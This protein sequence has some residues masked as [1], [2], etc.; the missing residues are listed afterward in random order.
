MRG[1]TLVVR[2]NTGIVDTSRAVHTHRWPCTMYVISYSDLV[3]Y[4]DK[5][6][7]L[8]N[9]RTLE[10]EPAPGQALW[11]D[12]LPPH[13]LTNVGSSDLRVITVEIK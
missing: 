11:S 7:V 6:K 2:C 3:R 5:G 13:S 12:P 9:S 8:L 1:G 4:D 10:K